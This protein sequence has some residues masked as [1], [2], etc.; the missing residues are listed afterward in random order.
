MQR[1]SVR[2]AP[3]HFI[4]HR[5]AMDD[6]N[7][8]GSVGSLRLEDLRHCAACISACGQAGGGF[9]KGHKNRCEGY[10]MAFLLFI[11]FP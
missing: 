7:F 10:V 8:D 3:V 9:G 1:F 4:E 11:D 6:R 2:G 5:R